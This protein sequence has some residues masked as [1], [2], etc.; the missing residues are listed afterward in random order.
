MKV[1]RSKESDD[2]V[3][4]ETR[5]QQVKRFVDKSKIHVQQGK[6]TTRYTQRKPD[7]ATQMSKKG[8]EYSLLYYFILLPPSVHKNKKSETIYL[9]RH[10]RITQ[11]EQFEGGYRPV[12]SST[13]LFVTSTVRKKNINTKLKFYKEHFRVFFRIRI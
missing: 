3:Q 2:M 7:S 1:E 10:T 13:I 11:H 12:T 8:W 9:T 5:G 6:E 4:R